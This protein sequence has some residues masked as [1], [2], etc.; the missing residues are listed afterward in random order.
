M[1]KGQWVK[2]KES[3]LWVSLAASLRPA[4]TYRACARLVRI[5]AYT[6]MIPA[7]GI[8]EITGDRACIGRVRCELTNL[9]PSIC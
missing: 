8:R 5:A 9:F 1:D 4:A 2:G 7:L 3:A 6:F